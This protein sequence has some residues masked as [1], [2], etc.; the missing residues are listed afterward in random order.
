MRRMLQKFDQW[1]PNDK[2]SN[3]Y[4]TQKTF[5]WTAF[6][7]NVFFFLLDLF[8]K[9]EKIQSVKKRSLH[10]G[11]LLVIRESYIYLSDSN[12]IN[13]VIK[14]FWHGRSPSPVTVLFCVILFLVQ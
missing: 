4:S 11:M 5:N 14:Y 7:A 3:Y 12:I 2:S 1:S 13:A 9:T 8:D 6:Q 10:M